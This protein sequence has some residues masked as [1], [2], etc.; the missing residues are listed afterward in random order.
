MLLIS[1]Y[2]FSCNSCSIYNF[3]LKI[4]DFSFS[5][6]Y[7]RFFCYNSNLCLEYCSS[8]SYSSKVSIID[9]FI[10]SNSK[11]DIIENLNKLMQLTYV[12]QKIC[13]LCFSKKKKSTQN[14]NRPLNESS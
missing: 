4:L 13:I 5:Y 1:C 10:K 3:D 12:P 2:I 9:E 7:I 14:K 8:F 11:M 6:F